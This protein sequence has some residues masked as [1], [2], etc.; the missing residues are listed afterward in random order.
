MWLALLAALLVP[1]VLVGFILWLVWIQTTSAPIA[2]EWAMV[3]LL[4]LRGTGQLGL[5]DLL[6]F[7]NEHRILV[8]RLIGLVIIDLTSWNRQIYMT[9]AVAAVGL[10]LL[11]LL[12]AYRHA[13]KS[14]LATVLMIAPW[15]LMILSLARWQ[16]WIAPFTDKIPTAFGVALCC[17]AFAARPLG[18]WWLGLA[19]A[20]ALIASFSS[21]G[22][23][24]IWL[25]F[26]P[27]AVISGRRVA[28]GWAVA[29]VVTIALYMIG[30]PRGAG[31][32]ALNPV[33][34]I[35]FILAYL[36]APVAGADLARAQIATLASL[37]VLIGGGIAAWRLGYGRLNPRQVLTWSGL[38]AFA[39]GTGVLA[40][41]SR[42]AT[43]GPDLALES[44]YLAFALFWWVWLFALGGLV[45]LEI[46]R[47]RERSIALTPP[48][49]TWLGAAAIVAVVAVVG[50]VFANLEG[51]PVGKRQAARTRLAQ[52]CILAYRYAADDCLRSFFPDP[53]L[54]RAD[55][56]YLDQFDLAIFDRFEAVNLAQLATL[57]PA[58]TGALLR[59]DEARITRRQEE[60]ILLTSGV[61]PR[62]VGWAVD[63]VVELP[64]GGVLIQID[65]GDPIWTAIDRPTPGVAGEDRPAAYAEA[66]F[67]I[68]LPAADLSPGEHIITMQAVTSDRR[69]VFETSPRS[70]RV[71]V[72]V[73]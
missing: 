7:H 62:L 71:V 59:L 67:A 10:T 49:R 26:L 68:T 31:E 14:T 20:G 16:N 69:S 28:A 51:H 61:S 12:L 63:P 23:L 45:A 3:D 38:G 21:F 17:W 40:A 73:D 36:G 66:G 60:P 70:Q 34:M 54:A 9:L 19:L 53:A 11:L 6:A 39:V 2:D 8:G 72:R 47:D 35:G 57:P 50:M 24:V 56:A 15:S 13:S 37:V 41:M 44:R 5:N 64:A 25:A 22:G 52:S 18:R 30:F 4:R 55:S 43:S 29:A 65:D 1:A 32:A 46:D 33:D 48:S 27:A 42:G 58:E